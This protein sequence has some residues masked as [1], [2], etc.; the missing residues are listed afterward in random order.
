MMGNITSSAVHHTRHLDIGCGSNPRNPFHCSELYGVDVISQEGEGFHYRQC[1]ILLEK[2][3]FSDA[4]FDSVS[5]FDFLEHIPRVVV[6]VDR[7]RFPFV[8]FMNEVYR[9]LKPG[10]I[11]YAITPYYPRPEAF[12]DP[13]HVNFITP[14]THSYFTEPDYGASVYGFTGKF[15]ALQVKKT[16]LSWESRPKKGLEAMLVTVYH[17]VS[18]RKKSHLLWVFQA[19]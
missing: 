2:L 5:C 15:R 3:P 1:N 19:Q 14:N 9:I 17:A 8:E 18:F 6:G 11:F 13:T 12:V 10:G 16:K 4:M 7:T